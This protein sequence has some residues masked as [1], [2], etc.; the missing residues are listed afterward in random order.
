MPLNQPHSYSV[1]SCELSVDHFEWSFRHNYAQEISHYWTHRCS[2][3][4][5]FF[6]GTVHLL[7]DFNTDKGHFRGKLFPIDFKSFLYWREHG[8]KD[9]TVYDIFGSALL[10]SKEGAVLLGRQRKGHIN[11]GLFY[12]PGGF[13]DPRDVV[14]N[15][16]CI[17]SSVVR[18]V[19]EETGLPFSH[20][21]PC[22]NFVITECQRQIS[23][24]VEIK[25]HLSTWELINT[26][27]NYLSKDSH[28]ELEEVIAVSHH[29]QIDPL[30]V[31]KYASTLL[32][33]VLR[34]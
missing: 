24:G 6:D 13:I 28:S 22:P 7:S 31:P 12:F 17:R 3:N 26:I 30:K 9:C 8:H 25:T 1:T 34:C 19:V 29:S 11:Q 16:V 15:K 27:T 5:H 14:S 21:L 33:Y 2:D 10:R 4:P 20:L 23:I 18:E 32:D